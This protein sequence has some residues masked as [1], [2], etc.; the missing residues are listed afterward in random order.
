MSNVYGKFSNRVVFGLISVRDQICRTIRGE[1]LF[2]FALGP[3]LYHFEDIPNE[4]SFELSYAD[5]RAVIL[6]IGFEIEVR[7]GNK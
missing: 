2:S 4:Q 3:L 1:I 5:L 6:S 7:F